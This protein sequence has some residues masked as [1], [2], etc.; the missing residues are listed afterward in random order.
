M[1]WF[2]DVAAYIQ[3]NLD[4]YVRTFFTT[5]STSQTGKTIVIDPCPFCGHHDCFTITRGINAAHCFSA[6]CNES[7]SLIQII[8]KINGIE[9]AREQLAKWS[10]IPYTYSNP[11]PE[12]TAAKEKGKRRQKIIK[13]AIK[14]FQR[15]LINPDPAT[16]LGVDTSPGLHQT[17][18]RKHT[19]EAIVESQMG[20]SGDFKSFKDF[21]VD[22]G[23]DE[24]EILQVKKD[25]FSFPEGYFIYP[26]YNSR[27]EI[28][29]MNG[30]L[31]L[32]TCFGKEK[33]NG[34]REFCDFRTQHMDKLIK[35]S[36]ESQTGHTMAPDNLSFGEKDDAFFMLEADLKNMKK[37]S[38]ILVEGE[39]DAIS[40]REALKKIPNFS[41][42]F[43]VWGI[44]GNPPIGIF[45]SPI[46][47]EF[48]EVY[49]AFDNDE[50]GASYRER[51]DSEA[52]E[53]IIKKLNIPENYK[54]PDLFVT[55]H[56][57]PAQAL[58]ELINSAVIQP[59]EHYKI[60]RLEKSHEWIIKSRQVSLAYEILSYNIRKSGFRGV[61]KTY[62][63]NTIKEKKEVDIDTAKG[64]HPP[65]DRLRSELSSRISDYYHQVR[66]ENGA[67]TRSFYELL[68][69]FRFTRNQNDVI[70]QLGWYL[71]KAP[72]EDYEKKCKII[73]A[74]IPREKDVASI[75][76]EYNGYQNEAI[77]TL[78]RYPKMLISQS[79]FPVNNDAYMYF[80][81]F[82][83]D[84][85]TPKRVPCLISNKKV[86]IRL[87]LLKR[88]DNQSILLIDNKYEL[89]MEVAHNI[90]DTDS[91]SLQQVWVERWI[92]DDI[93][94][95]QI[96]PTTIINEI[97]AFI[98]A[99]YHTSDEVIKV[100]SLWI[101]ATY[102]YQI[103]RSGFP[104]LMFQGA[105]G[106]GKSTLDLIIQLLSFNPTFTVSATEAALYRQIS[107]IGGTFILDEVENLTDAN[108]VSESGLATVIKAGYSD[109]GTVMRINQDTK[110][111]ESFSVFGPKV[112]SNI[113]G[114]DDVILDRCILITTY[115]ASKDSLE[116]LQDPYEFK[117]DRREFV[118]SISSRAA[119]SAL[120]HFNKVYEIFRNDTRIETGN[121]RL[122][123]ILRP[124]V[125]MAR[126]VGGDYEK[127]LL[128]YYETDIKDT[129]NEVSLSTL[130]G[131]IKHIMITVCE[132]ILGLAE[133]KMFVDCNHVYSKP[134]NYNKDTLTFELDDMHLKIF[135][136]E[137]E[138]EKV[139]SFKQ[140]HAA[141]KNVY[142]KK[143]DLK[144][145]KTRTRITLDNED[146]IRQTGGKRHPQG[147]RYLFN[148]RDFIPKHVEVM[149][150]EKRDTNP[151]F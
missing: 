21:M 113:N 19:Y 95:I 107:M 69:I 124:L 75:L 110:M 56:P 88:K 135:A 52:P 91:L 3:L 49:E 64:I 31:Y 15:R 97:E 59:T 125:T 33:A 109:A 65:Y 46:L 96:H 54:D 11:T 132:E 104:Y 136:E 119:I 12:R 62:K 94:E 20:Y 47:R 144:A 29:R 9:E 143:L 118:H 51:L 41:S 83:Q 28:V 48:K 89:P 99:T 16:M 121:A 101:Y 58:E 13:A 53:V 85:E 68:D 84:G 147:I 129:K 42:R 80:T 66:W 25:L 1:S 22:K 108:K 77:D 6:S 100:L 145:A 137:L 8:E 116:A 120:T 142:G 17:D 106:T 44:G 126:L 140:I 38:L 14:F 71:Y 102:F 81:K 43:A 148:V 2:D 5:S 138:T 141:L 45:E 90:A 36:H 139:Y 115:S 67:P 57:E 117:G 82:V 74:K 24:E 87:D 34:E 127:H 76:K 112:I 86:E 78:A 23:Y 27:G 39:N 40:L 98:R 131:K 150:Y 92:N 61:L 128:A 32:R 122:T 72:K 134:V 70:K 105:K 7:G 146:L 26:Y 50:G 79:F 10:G 133:T 93:D 103:F 73:K 60:E 63:N 123:Q 4:D 18:V 130:E 111:P 55:T 151:L 149:E 30:K 114:I 37:K 35:K